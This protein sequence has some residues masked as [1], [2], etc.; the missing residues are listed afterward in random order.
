MRN[1]RRKFMVVFLVLTAAGTHAETNETI[2]LKLWSD[3]EFLRQFLGTYGVRSEIEPRVTPEERKEFE[4]FSKL[5]VT[6]VGAEKALALLEKSV[7]KA[8]DKKGVS[9][10]SALYDFTIGSI[11]FQQDNLDAAAKWYGKAVDKLPSFLRAQKNLGLV[12]VRSNAFDRAVGPLTRAIDL[13]AADGLT[14][15]LLAH[16][17]AMTE[18]YVAAESAYRQAMML[19]PESIDWKNGL[20]RCLFKERKF[21]E[22]AALCGDMIRRDPR[23]TDLWLLQA[24]AWLSL[25]Q[26]LKAA[27]NYELLDRAGLANVA[28]L[29]TLGDIYINEGVPEMAVSAYLRALTKDGA[30]AEPSTALRNAEVLAARSAYTEAGSLLTRVKTVCG[31]KL[32]AAEKKRVLKLEARMAAATGQNDTEQARLLEDIVALDPLDGETLILLAQ[33]YARTG[34]IDKA[35]FLCERAAGIEK[36]E[37]EAKLRHGQILVKAGKFQEALPLLKRALELKPREE[38]Q[39]YVEQVE[40]AA[41]KN[42]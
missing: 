4:Q 38:V 17:Y 3:P 24:N 41:R 32:G 11:Y 19:Q 5:M 42:G 1:V 39:R 2:E 27:E 30:N 10:S 25:K 40:R 20:A 16:S 26:P 21:E 13:G 33:H 18:Q 14:F 29:N 15:G 35:C 28:C 36:Y 34:N 6:P 7:A 23:R 22:A 31:A 12:Y 37:A 8:I 9:L